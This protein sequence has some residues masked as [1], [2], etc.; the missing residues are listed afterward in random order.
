[1]QGKGK[2]GDVEDKGIPPP[3]NV[4]TIL[5][6][7]RRG[8]LHRTGLVTA[9]TIAIHNF[10]EGL[11]T[12]VVA[13]G[14]PVAGYALAIAI[15]LHNIPEGIC[16]AMPVYYA[17]SSKWQAFGWTV[18]AGVAEPI[19]GLVGYFILWNST[20]P[21]TLG[22]MFSAVAGM[23]VYIS[24]QELIPEALRFDPENSV[25]MRFLFLGMAVVATSLILIPDH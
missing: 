16:V 12:F 5:S 14:D 6:A 11:A 13:V 4:A 17:T 23:M 8:G 3:E 9:L 25:T 2:A 22:I 24:F 19:G 1:M 10:P 15:A 20:T 7:E 21:L 18:L